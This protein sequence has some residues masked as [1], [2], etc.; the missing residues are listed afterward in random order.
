MCVCTC[1][2]IYAHTHR[3]TCV[4]FMHILNG[5]CHLSKKWT[6]SRQKTEQKTQPKFIPFYGTAHYKTK[7]D[8][9]KTQ[10][11]FICSQ[12]QITVAKTHHCSASF[13]NAGCVYENH[14]NPTDA[15]RLQDSSS[16]SWAAL[17]KGQLLQ[18][19]SYLPARS[20]E[21]ASVFILC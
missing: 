5:W 1:V 18:E 7:R 8:C 9:C 20:A 12:A 14:I 6:K 10:E 3:Y 15:N 11:R 4:W 16:A 21:L 13:S 17:W 2:H 19:H